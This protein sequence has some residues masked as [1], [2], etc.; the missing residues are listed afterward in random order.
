MGACFEPALWSDHWQTCSNMG[1]RHAAQT[2]LPTGIAAELVAVR[3]P[4]SYW[5]AITPEGVASGTYKDYA[6]R[7]IRFHARLARQGCGSCGRQLERGLQSTFLGQVNK[8][9]LK[10][11]V[12]RS[13]D[14]A[15]EFLNKSDD[16]YSPRPFPSRNPICDLFTVGEVVLWSFV[17]VCAVAILATVSSVVPVGFGRMCRARSRPKGFVQMRSQLREGRNG[18]ASSA[19]R[20]M[21]GRCRRW[22]VMCA[23]NGAGRNQRGCEPKLSCS[24]SSRVR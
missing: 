6:T 2:D 12:V 24:A 19:R 4:R 16:L 10:K 8:G 23:K 22:Q 3:V 20:R 13:R 17:F 18:R 5:D 21:C 7:G 11:P 9:N 1:R 14:A 15:K